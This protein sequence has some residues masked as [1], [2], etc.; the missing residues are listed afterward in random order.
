MKL[1]VQLRIHS[2]YTVLHSDFV[3]DYGDKL[4]VSNPRNKRK[5]TLQLEA[6]SFCSY[7]SE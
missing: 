3:V 1:F 5:S 2:I 6:I 7:S 4:A